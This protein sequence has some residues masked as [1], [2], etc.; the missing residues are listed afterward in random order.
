MCF[1]WVYSGEGNQRED[2]L[3]APNLAQHHAR[4]ALLARVSPL[5][6]S[7][8]RRVDRVALQEGWCLKLNPES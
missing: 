8:P 6:R 2:S 4:L 7:L 1:H 3:A 5:L